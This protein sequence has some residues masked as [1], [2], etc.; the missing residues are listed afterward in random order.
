MKSSKLIWL[1]VALLLGLMSCKKDRFKVANNNPNQIGPVDIAAKDLVVPAKFNFETEKE[2][3]LRVAVANPSHPG[4][5]YVIKIFSEVPSTG[6]LIATGITNPSTYEYSTTVRVASYEDYIYIQ[7]INENGNSEYQKVKADKFVKTLFTGS[8][9]DGKYTFSKSGS[10]MS[11][12]SGCS[13]T[14]NNLSGS[15]SVNNNKTNCYTGNLSGATITVKSGGTAK[16]CGTGTIASLTVQGSGKVYFLE[17]SQVTISSFSGNSKDNYIKNWSDSLTFAGSV[18]LSGKL[19]NYGHLHIGGTLSTN[20]NSYVK[21]EDVFRVAGSVTLSDDFKNYH[22]FLV[23]GSLDVYSNGYL[24]NN[25]FTSVAGDMTT[26]GNLWNGG[27]IKVGE[28]FKVNSTTSA[29]F[30]DGAVVFTKDFV[31]NGDIEGKGTDRSKI[32]V[33]ATTT[34]NSTGDL[35]GKL[36]ICDANGIETNN[37]NITSPA[38][39]DCGGYICTSTCFPEGY[40]QNTVQDADNDGV[41]DG[42]DEYPNDA[43]RAFTSYYPSAN[44]TATLAFEDLWPGTGDYDYNDLVLSYNITKVLNADNEV[45]DYKVKL[46]VRAIGASYDNGFGFQLDELVPGDIATVTGQSIIRNYITLNA[47]KTEAS[48]A[49]AVIICYDTPEPYLHRAAGSFFNT[50]QTNGTGT[51]DTMY[52]NVTFASPVSDSKLGIEKFNPFII[53]KQR[54]DYEVHLGNF[55]PTDLAATNLFGTQQDRTNPSNSVYY[56]TGNGMPWVI[57]LPADFDYPIER[58]PIT[59]AFNFFDDWAVS[60]GSSN[61]DWYT[62]NPG[63]RNSENIYTPN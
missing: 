12:S 13:Y 42:Q 63:N 50:I 54:R 4:E 24:E 10:G 8:P 29:E 45:V 59:S 39:A 5:R 51:S 40:G 20:S 3:T 2:L 22:Y 37:G 17:N 38:A 49:K 11:C 19:Y 15:S 58:V 53:T 46:K 60:G 21:N 35:D 1:P 56:K 14:V 7:K 6:A 18:T 52:V 34:I 33:S 43:S 16:I 61:T 57:S 47:N 27:F 36:D 25:C 55:H 23:G 30:N 41:A 44:T 48:Q 32:K 26:S 28:E 31:L 9:N 62:A